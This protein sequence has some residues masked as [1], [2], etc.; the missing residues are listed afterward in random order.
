MDHILHHIFKIILGISSKNM[1]QWLINPQWDDHGEN[2]SPLEITEVVLVPYNIVQNDYQ[3]LLRVLYT[4]VA[5]KLFG[6][7]FNNLP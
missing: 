3:H 4:F 5:N 6:E 7:L 1:K 2:V